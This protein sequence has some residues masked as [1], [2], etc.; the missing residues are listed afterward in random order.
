VGWGVRLW[1]RRLAFVSMRKSAVEIEKRSGFFKR[2]VLITQNPEEFVKT[3]KE[4]LE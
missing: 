4:N 2:L 1:G 3:I